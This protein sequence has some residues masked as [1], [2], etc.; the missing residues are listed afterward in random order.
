METKTQL[1]NACLSIIEKRIQTT[2]DALNEAIAA[3][4]E[5]TKSSV[6]DKH[7][8]G[9]AMMQLEQEKYQAQLINSIRLKNEL[10]QIDFL[11]KYE[12]IIKGALVITNN[13]N[14]F[15][16]AS[17]GKIIIGQKIYYA[18]SVK[19]PLAKALLGKQVNESVFF[20][21]I[22]YMVLDIQ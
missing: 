10:S 11:N 9:R 21:N 14:Y 17:V 7:E 19:A 6:G 15:I 2:Q 18:I 5:E 4:N 16:S 12:K 8:T 13:G 22:K 3:G 1:Y 20:Q